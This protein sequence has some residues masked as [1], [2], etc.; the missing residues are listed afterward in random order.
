MVLGV[1]EKGRHLYLFQIFLDCL[2]VFTVHVYDLGNFK[3]S[4]KASETKQTQITLTGK[5]RKCHKGVF[6]GRLVAGKSHGFQ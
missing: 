6:G 4:V 3:D 1:G 2:H 5:E